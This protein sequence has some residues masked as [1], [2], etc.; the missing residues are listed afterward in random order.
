MDSESVW[1]IR[2]AGI[3]D[4]LGVN[5]EC[6]TM[7]L[8]GFVGAGAVCSF[9]CAGDQTQDLWRAMDPL[10]PRSTPPALTLRVSVFELPGG[11]SC[12]LLKLVKN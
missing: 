7:T 4:R 11:G 8:T 1:R 5:I 9:V 10:Y 12:Y 2:Q 6:P 3:A